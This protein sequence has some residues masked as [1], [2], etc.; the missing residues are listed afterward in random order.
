MIAAS[1]C[2]S[3]ILPENENKG[4]LRS[5]TKISVIIP[6][7]N[8][9]DYLAEAIQSVLDQTF[10]DFELIIVDDGSTDN[11]KEVVEGFVDT[12]VRYLFQ[13]NGGVSSAR[14]SG[15]KA[16][17][18]EYIAFLDSDDIWLPENLALK[19]NLLDSRPDIGLVC[20]DA[21]FFD[22]I[23]GTVLG[24][25]WH[26]Q[27]LHDWINLNKIVV[28]PLKE[29]LCKGCFIM[30]QAT[31]VRSQVFTTV[32]YFDESL[33]TSEDWDLFVRIFQRFPLEII[34]TPLLKIRRHSTSLSENQE[35]V[36]Q[37]AVAAVNKAI[38]SGSFSGEELKLLNERLALEHCK[39]GRLA[40]LGGRET[41]ARKALIAGIRL[42]PWK[43]KL[44]GYLLL[45]L[46]GT[47]KI[48]VLKS[49]KRKLVRR[50]SRRQSLSDT[51][52]VTNQ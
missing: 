32:G 36:Y 5:V 40:L 4:W 21:Y 51:R 25:R 39:Y 16:A 8:R 26:D 22:N 14:N 9:A 15:I 12:R 52:S 7:Y 35:K 37:G 34:D 45:S 27:T 30:P 23:T 49:W 20:S 43:I 46:L 11:T 13:E 38:D 28:Q 48:L 19:V 17:N 2:Q 47:K 3:E 18:G 44:Y 41:A 31:M 24:R 29:L 33:P 1:C 6:A 10:P 50:P 42:N